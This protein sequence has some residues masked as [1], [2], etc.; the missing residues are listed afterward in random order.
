MK[1]FNAHLIGLS[2]LGLTHASFAD[3]ILELQVPGPGQKLQP[4]K[5]LIK[6]NMART[7]TSRP[8]YYM[9]MNLDNN[10]MFSV[11]SAAQQIIDMSKSKQR[12][13]PKM[14]TTTTVKPVTLVKTQV[15][16]KVAGYDTVQYKL[17]IEDKVCG[18]EYVSAKAQKLKEVNAFVKASQVI[19]RKRMRAL[20]SMPFIQ[21]DPCTLASAQASEQV[22]KL[23]LALRSEDAKGNLRREVVSIK[24]DLNLSDD[25]FA[26][27]EAY[28]S[29]TPIE[30]MQRNLKGAFKNSTS[31]G[32]KPP[33]SPE[34][35]Q[36]IREA[37]MKR[38]QAARGTE[39]NAPPLKPL[40]VLPPTQ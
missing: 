22:A 36:K 25:K 34:A 26:L 7:E 5:V 17:M 15:S 35:Q 3:T 18:F 29:L 11:N 31:I 4:Q 32:G 21:Q 28:E 2:L 13:P 33:T 9:L 40:L 6:G 27:P 12:P 24:T 14:V 37:L 20:A 39:S 1:T 30:M 38:L 16:K 10:D 8:D 23:G 19:Q